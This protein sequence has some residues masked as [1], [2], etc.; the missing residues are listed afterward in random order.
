LPF[1]SLGCVFPPKVVD[2][3]LWLG[4][5]TSHAWLQ[6]TL[7]GEE[8]DVCP[9]SVENRPGVTEFEFVWVGAWRGCRSQP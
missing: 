1:F 9:G 3:A 4:G 8:R 7:A 6:V 5:R 2:G